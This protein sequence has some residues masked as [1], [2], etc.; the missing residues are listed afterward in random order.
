[1]HFDIGF[2]QVV[3]GAVENVTQGGQGERRD[4][5]RLTGYQSI[6]LGVGEVDAREPSSGGNSVDFQ[7][8][9]AAITRRRCL[10]KP[11]LRCSAISFTHAQASA[12]HLLND[13]L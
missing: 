2:E 12:D 6:D 10:W 8:L 7:R 4:A 5:L 9:W 3:G 11:I 13:L 1:L